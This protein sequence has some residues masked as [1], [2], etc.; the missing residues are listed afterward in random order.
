MTNQSWLTTPS[1]EALVEDVLST[2][3]K[4]YRIDERS[5]KNVIEE[6]FLKDEDLRKVVEK[7]ESSSKIKRTRAFKDAA[8]EVKRTI[9]YGLR[10]YSVD[11]VDQRD[12]IAKLSKAED[13]PRQEIEALGLEIA[14]SHASTKE[15][16][17]HRDEFYRQLLPLIGSPASILDVGSGMQPL[18]F[19]FAQVDNELELYLAA[20]KDADS[21]AAVNGYA[22]ALGED[23]LKAIIWD[24][25]EGWQSIF[26]KSG[27]SSFDVAFLFKLVPVIERQNPELLE[28]LIETPARRWVVTGSM[29]SLTKRQRIEKRE[30][31]II[32]RFCEAANRHVIH[33]FSVAE[34][35]G[36]VAE[37]K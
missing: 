33:E 12:L 15:R 24:L 10:R 30:R 1:G 16:L 34:E 35:F 31:A 13:T 17:D 32:R 11:R 4:R 20:D 28:I 26:E 6:I 18:L 37:G 19:P 14:R 21:I 29:I 25:R 9:Y 23:R 7:E 5:A 22:K 8:A 27:V 2:V 36:I 3:V